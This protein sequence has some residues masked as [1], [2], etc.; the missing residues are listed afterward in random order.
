MLI[1]KGYTLNNRSTEERFDVHENRRYVLNG[2]KKP[3]E[4]YRQLS[5]YC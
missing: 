5:G 1:E 2:M 3:T 4:Y